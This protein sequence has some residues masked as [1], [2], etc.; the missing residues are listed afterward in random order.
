[1]TP[2]ITAIALAATLSTSQAPSQCPLLAPI[3]AFSR[4][5]HWPSH[6]LTGAGVIA[7]LPRGW[8]VKEDGRVASAESADGQLWLTIR[9]GDAS[10]EAYLD[11]V[12]RAV[13]LVELGPSTLGGTCEARLTARLR[14]LGGWGA[15]RLSV[16]RRAFGER[17]RAFALFASLPSGTMTA[18]L[19]VK[20]RHDGGMPMTL[21][22]QLLSG[23]HALQ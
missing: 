19:T 13:E 15:L 8:T 5:A 3:D 2:F 21:V 6:T 14:D 10:D 12:R 9:R 20:W 16:S 22:R 7:S 4:P 17:R 11:R 23:L 18:V 1:M